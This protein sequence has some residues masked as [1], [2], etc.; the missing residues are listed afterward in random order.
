W[1]NAGASFWVSAMPNSGYQFS[2]FSPSGF[3]YSY[4]VVMNGPVTTSAIFVNVPGISIMTNPALAGGAV[5][6]SYSV[7]FVAVGGTS[8][9]TWSVVSG[10]AP[11]NLILSSSGLLSGTPNTPGSFSFSLQAVDSASHTATQT[12]NVTMAPYV[13]VTN[14]TQNGWQLTIA[15]TH[16]GVSG[17]VFFSPGNV[18]SPSTTWSDTQI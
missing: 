15:G 6:T 18:P 4:Q 14:V 11:T 1:Y 5:G 9:Y 13:T 12:F 2:S 7:Q 16:F 17:T 10:T 3:T 8:P